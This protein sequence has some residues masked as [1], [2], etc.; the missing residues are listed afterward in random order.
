MSKT[1]VYSWR[2]SAATKGAIEAEA[3]KRN[4]SV[5]ALLDRITKE[6][7]ESGRGQ[8][9]EDEQQARLH[10]AVRKTLGTVAGNNPKRSK[11]VRDLTR[12]RIRRSHGR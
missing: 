12:K 5:A 8:D 10:L 11:Q 1:E 7:I 6:W 4:V 9:D 2:V 3:R